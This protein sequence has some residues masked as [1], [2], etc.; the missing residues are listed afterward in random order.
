MRKLFLSVFIVSFSFCFGQQS[1]IIVNQDSISEL[2]FK[3]QYQTNIEAE[4]IENAIET[5][6]DFKLLQQAAHKLQVDTMR[7]FHRIFEE[8]IR[9][10]R[11]QYIYLPEIKE[12]LV[13]EIWQNL[14]TDRQAEVYAMGIQNP[15][16]EE[17]KIKKKELVQDLHHY[18]CENQ[19]TTSATEYLSNNPVRKSWVRPFSIS[20]EIERA[21]YQTPIGN[22]SEIQT[23]ERGYFFVKVL[24]ERPSSGFTTFDYIFNVDKNKLEQAQRSL[25]NQEEWK[26]VKNLFHQ[27]LNDKSSGEIQRLGENI[28]EKFLD[29]IHNNGQNNFTEIVAYDQG[30][31]L[32]RLLK[33][34]NFNDLNAWEDWIHERILYSS[35]AN[36][37]LENLEN[38]AMKLVKIEEN[39][40]AIQ[41]VIQVLMKNN[42]DKSSL[43]FA[44]NKPI[45]LVDNQEFN[46][47]DLINELSNAKQ[48]FDENVALNLLADDMIPKLK[49]QFVLNQYL[50]NL[51]FY[52]ND[53]AEFSNLLKESIKINHLI[54]MEVNAKA[55][56]DTLGLKNYLYQNIE[57]FIW[58]KSYDLE[59]YRYG[60]DDDAEKIL[61]FLKNNKNNEEIMT[62]FDGKTDEN[63][64]LSV[65][66]TKAK[67][68]LQHPELPKDFNPKKKIQQIPYKSTMAIIKLNAVLEPH[69]MQF[70]EVI[71][72]LKEMYKTHLYEQTLKNLR[73]E[74]NIFV[75]STLLNH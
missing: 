53:F 4:G 6:I 74:A 37:Y 54:E 45:W 50:G 35:Y 13:T 18:V 67:I 71:M 69:P 23:S 48:L 19:I 38:R 68:P 28:P 2:E 36:D 32:I 40:D 66:Y 42:N 21:I 5:Y 24:N 12:K 10:E 49:K 62:Y 41:E 39:Q 14:Q 20:S 59:I 58:P 15:F 64:A 61:Q 16:D 8:S 55:E 44:L 72:P 25:Q 9:P 47:S 52:D 30:F 43:S 17:N 29:A 57:K 70:E 34:E 11:E 46:Q 65:I 7:I 26:N 51:E 31:Y 75:P 22:C 73:E 27:K 56:N 33:Q 63:G 60:N 3:N 1:Y